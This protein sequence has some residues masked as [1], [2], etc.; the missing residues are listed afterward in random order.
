MKILPWM[1]A[2]A[3]TLFALP[4]SAEFYK[5]LD[6]QGNTRFT[7]DINQVPPEQR[8]GLKSYVESESQPEPEPP[9]TDK[10]PEKP[11]AGQQDAADIYADEKPEA[12]YYEKTRKE[13]DKM[14]SELDA[15]YRAIMEE[16]QILTEERETAKSREQIM[17][18]NKKV[19]KLN[20]RAAAYETKGAEY[21]SRVEA[22]N[23]KI[24]EENSKAK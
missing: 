21:S 7:D 24:A 3:L 13:L 23:A 11:V 12:G 18:Y 19:E 4:A 6:E 1:L 9:T 20:E 22:F 2:I 15:E 17:E 5:Y 14:K 10:A 8:K 16:K